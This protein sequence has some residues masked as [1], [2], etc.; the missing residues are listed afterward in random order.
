MNWLD[1]VIII[2]LIISAFGGLASGLIKS[3]LSLVGLIVGVVLAGRFYIG[4]SGLLAFIQNQNIARIV[5]FLIIFLIVVV[6][7]AVLGSILTKAV[8]ALLLGWL[9]RLGG[10][11]FGIILGA[12]F[13]AAI[14]VILAKYAGGNSVISGSAIAPV[15]V[16][17]FPLVLALLPKEFDVVR[18]FFQ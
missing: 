5:A 10:A 3:V 6:I 8:S 15:L 2:L 7:A 18:Q 11:V 13:I 9:N 4:L 17:R 16:D 12:V 14:L 1:I